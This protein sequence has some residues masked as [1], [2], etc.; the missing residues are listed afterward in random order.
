MK[1]VLKFEWKKWVYDTAF[2]P[3]SG[4]SVI[5]AYA[6]V[7]VKFTI[8]FLEDKRCYSNRDSQLDDFLTDLCSRTGNLNC[9][10]PSGS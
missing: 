8:F 4:L 2:V 10:F 3:S 9:I 6:A 7:L 1:T 5:A